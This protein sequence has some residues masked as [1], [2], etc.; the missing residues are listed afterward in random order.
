MRS[1]STEKIVEALI[2][3]AQGKTLGPNQFV[4]TMPNGD[5]T[6][7]SYDTPVAARIGGKYYRTDKKWSNTTS[8]HISNYLGGEEAEEKPQEFFDNL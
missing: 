2:G 6:F 8:K 1:N 5:E 7:F 4:H 3:E